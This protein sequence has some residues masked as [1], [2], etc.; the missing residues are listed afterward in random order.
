[1]SVT[2]YGASDD[3]IEIEG[4]IREEFTYEGPGHGA[5]SGDLLAFSDGTILRIEYADT[6]I[7]RIAPVVHGTA[8]LT[9]EQAPEDDESN[10]SDRAT[11]SFAAWVVQGVAFARSP[12]STRRDE[13]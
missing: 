1:M 5:G 12:A 8:H 10:Y 11:L 9:F 13:Q 6:G 7:W 3:L 4:D 2:V